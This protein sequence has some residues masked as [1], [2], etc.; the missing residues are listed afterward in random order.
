VIVIAEIRVVPGSVVSVIT[1]GS[2]LPIVYDGFV[3]AKAAQ[4][5]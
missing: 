2:A 5:G 1:K 4:F 3:A